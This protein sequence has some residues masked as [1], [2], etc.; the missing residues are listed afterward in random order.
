MYYPEIFSTQKATAKQIFTYT[1][2]IESQSRIISIHESRQI[3]IY[4]GRRTDRRRQN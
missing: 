1:V 2:D 4:R 3:P